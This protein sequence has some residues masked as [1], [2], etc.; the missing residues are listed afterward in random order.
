MPMIGTDI[1]FE[2]TVA[3]GCH[4]VSIGVI[5]QDGSLV[6]FL[7][8]RFKGYIQLVHK[9]EQRKEAFGGE[10]RL[11]DG[12]PFWIELRTSRQWTASCR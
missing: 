7:R 3:S 2:F 1:E 12:L 9:K 11:H 6:R 8:I 5:F 4:W 10:Y